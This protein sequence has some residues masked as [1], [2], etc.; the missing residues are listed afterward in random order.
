LEGKRGEVQEEEE[1][2]IGGGEGVRGGGGGARGGGGFFW[3]FFLAEFYCSCFFL[4]FFFRDDSVGGMLDVPEI[5]IHEPS[6]DMMRSRK[7]HDNKVP[8]RR[9]SRNI[10]G[11]REMPREKAG[12]T[13]RQQQGKISSE[14]CPHRGSAGPQPERLQSGASPFRRKRTPYGRPAQKER[15]RKCANL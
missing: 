6:A 9:A 5:V 13:P 2:R 7:I 14:C 8:L 11:Q 15:K 3:F 1:G 4:F 10:S 12:T